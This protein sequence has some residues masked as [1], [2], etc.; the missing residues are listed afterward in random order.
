MGW[1]Y[2]VVKRVIRDEPEYGIKE[3]YY[4]S[5]NGTIRSWSED[6]MEPSG[7]TLR[8]LIEDINLMLEAVLHKPMLEEK[9]GILI[10]IKEE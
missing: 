9:N 3:V 6:Y 4:N 8:E 1:N 2:R 10:E 5:Q 7:N